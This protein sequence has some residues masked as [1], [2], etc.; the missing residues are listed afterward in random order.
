MDYNTLAAQDRIDKTTAALKAN[1]FDVVVVEKGAEALERIK[2][3]IPK[4]ASVMNGSSTTL[5]QIGFVD[6]LKSGT[7]GWK[8]LHEDILN[9]KDPEK[10]AQLRKLSVVSDYYLG[11]A[12]AVTQEGMLMFASN[13]GSQLPHLAFTSPNIILVVSTKKIVKDVADGFARID[14]HILPL[15]DVRLMKQYGAHTMHS[16]TLILHKE[17]PMMKRKVLVMFVKEDLGF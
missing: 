1:N 4:D 9:E 8:N 17:N 13:T 5:N 10:Q 14:T 16:K 2:E 7:H 12:H 15:E 3:L 11:S 6:Y